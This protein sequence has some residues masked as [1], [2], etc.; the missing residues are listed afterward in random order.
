MTLRSPSGTPF[1]LQRLFTMYSKVWRALIMA[2][3]YCF[4][5]RHR[6]VSRRPASINS[7]AVFLSPAIIPSL[8][9]YKI[10]PLHSGPCGAPWQGVSA[11]P[12]R[13]LADPRFG[14]RVSAPLHSG[15]DGPSFRAARDASRPGRP[16]EL[17]SVRVVSKLPL[18][19]FLIL[20]GADPN[21]HYTKPAFLLHPSFG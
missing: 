2:E 4:C 12:T 13:V 7:L 8:K 16:A 20:R 10:R 14:R 19:R 3:L 15:P 11:P 9:Y 21:K 6:S 18:G 1:L 5:E 17:R